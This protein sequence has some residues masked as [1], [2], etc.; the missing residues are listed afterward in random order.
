M[1]QGDYFPFRAERVSVGG[2]VRRWCFRLGVQFVSI[3]F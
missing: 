2:E 1:S 3:V